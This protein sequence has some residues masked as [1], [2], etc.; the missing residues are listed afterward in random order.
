MSDS[1][2][3][4][5]SRFA[6]E[7]DQ[8]FEGWVGD[9]IFAL[10]MGCVGECFFMKLLYT[11]CII[12]RSKT[13]LFGLLFIVGHGCGSKEGR[14]VGFRVRG[15]IRG[16]FSGIAWI[17]VVRGYW[18][19]WWN[20]FYGLGLHQETGSLEVGGQTLFRESVLVPME[21][22]PMLHIHKFWE[23][24]VTCWFFFLISFQLVPF[25]FVLI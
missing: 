25:N 10:G 19:W 22:I 11:L 1:H 9:I 21:L 5:S 2:V 8:W 23:P 14:V 17:C 12:S 18:F 13:S 7:C 6:H 16:W 20:Q 15:G 4:F 3:T 24:F